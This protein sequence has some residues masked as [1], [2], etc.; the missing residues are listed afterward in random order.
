MSKPRQLR[1]SESGFG[2][3]VKDPGW[4]LGAWAV[5]WAGLGCVGDCSLSGGVGKVLGLWGEPHVCVGGCWGEA[6]GESWRRSGLLWRQMRGA[7]SQADLWGQRWMR[8]R[9]GNIVPST[10]G[11]G[12]ALHLL[13]S[14]RGPGLA[15][16]GVWQRLG[17]AGG[18]SGAGP[19]VEEVAMPTGTRCH[20]LCA[21]LAAGHEVGV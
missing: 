15:R 21:G 20:A 6:S 9:R 5:G 13:G 12:E 16:A 19:G 17:L 4:G 10:G 18:G 11:L 1:D 2:G 8:W 14:G 7:R 3:G